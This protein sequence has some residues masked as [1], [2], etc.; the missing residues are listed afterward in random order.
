MFN[1]QRKSIQRIIASSLLTGA[2]TLLPQF[3][4]A[5]D[6]CDIV[7]E[8]TDAMTFSSKEIA[9]KKSCKAF[10]ITLKH[11]GK[12]GKNIMGHNLVIAK[13]ADQKAVLEDGS[14]AGAANEYLKPNDT[15]VVAYTK[16]IGGG[17]QAA[18]QFALTKLDTKANYVFFCSFPG[19]A[20]M[21]KGVVKFI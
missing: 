14:K 3:A 5:A 20:F 16:L 13:E 18:T 21:M 19:H 7:I 1:Q 11:V 4:M 12:L 2:V 6:G 8:A 17:E 10:N 9:V 15:R